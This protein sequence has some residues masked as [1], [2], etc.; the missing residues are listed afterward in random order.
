VPPLL[1]ESKRTA[2]IWLNFVP[3][4][5]D[6][7]ARPYHNLIVGHF[8]FESWSQTAIWEVKHCHGRIVYNSFYFQWF[9]DRN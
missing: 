6:L 2:R 5:L 1:L 9:C 3:V 4:V 7:A 8:N